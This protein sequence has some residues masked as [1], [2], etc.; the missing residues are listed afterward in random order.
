LVRLRSRAARGVDW[1]R[2]LAKKGLSGA[3]VHSFFQSGWNLAAVAVILAA[4]IIAGALWFFPRPSAPP[5]NLRFKSIFGRNGQDSFSMK[6][7]SRFSPDGKMIAFAAPGD[8]ENI[9]LRQ[10]SGEH[11]TPIT[12]DKCLDGSPVWSPDGERIAFVSNRANQIG[13]WAIPSLGGGAPVL[14]K[15]LADNATIP[16]TDR[17]RLVA[18]TKNGTDNGPAIY[19]ERGRKLFR[20]D[21]N[22]KEIT[23]AAQFDQSL[24]NVY[25]F[26]LSTDGQEVAFSAQM[27]GQFDIWRI[28]I[29]GGKPQRV[30]ND[31]AED[32]RSVWRPDGK[33]YYES[34]RDGKTQLYLA[35]PSGGEPVLIPTGDHQCLLHDYSSLNNSLLCYEYRDDSDIFSLAIGSGVETQVTN[36][37]GAEFWS[38]V[39]PNGAML[40]YHAIPGERFFWGPR[41]S[42]LFT[43]PLGVKGQSILLATESSEA[44][45]SPNGEQIG[46]LRMTG[47]SQ[48]LWTINAAGGEPRRLMSGNISRNPYRAS[49]PFNTVHPRVWGWSTDSGRIAYCASQDGVTGVWT[50]WVDGSLTTQVT[51]N[52]DRGL[53]FDSPFWSPDGSRLAFASEPSGAS[54]KKNRSLWVTNGETPEMIF[55]TESELRLLG[56]FG[57]DRL[58]AA[59]A[60]QFTS[61]WGQPTTVKLLCLTLAGTGTSGKWGSVQ[62]WLGSLSE[63]YWV[64]LHLSPNGDGVAFVKAPN[65][66]NE[67]CL[68]RIY[69]VP[70]AGVRMGEPQKLANNSDPSVFFSSLAWSP[71]GKTIYYDKQTRLN[72]LTMIENLN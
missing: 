25:N 57:N 5:S 29:H 4:L 70:D 22:S 37:L 64:N 60:D 66:R 42:Q 45:W 24:D 11:E 53:Q 59:V 34:L 33:L 52:L 16:T 21:L 8:G 1:G 50:K 6:L 61:S 44:Q 69:V 18:W 67:I 32:S 15:K 72:Q 51:S 43:K 31:A 19:F 27:G 56:W 28:S 12:F 38:R 20:L 65:G 68:V 30:T 26:S 2:D 47:Q 58:L 9:Y 10:I 46:F 55:Q 71:D 35:D 54:L 39:S 40:L 62:N 14:I 36:D 23:Q 49:P 3:G 63:T 41:T 17:P 7:Q 13:V 48:N